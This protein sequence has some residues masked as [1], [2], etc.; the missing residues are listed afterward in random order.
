MSPEPNI[1]ETKLRLKTAEKVAT[2]HKAECDRLQSLTPDAFL[3]AHARE[4]RDHTEESA[5]ELAETFIDRQRDALALAFRTRMDE[6]IGQSPQDGAPAFETAL[7]WAR[8]ALALTPRDRTLLMLID[9][10]KGAAAIAAQSP[11]TV[12]LKNDADRQDRQT[13]ADRLPMDI[14]ALTAAFFKARDSGQYALMSFLAEHGLTITRRPPFG[15]GSKAHLMFRMHRVEALKYGGQAPDAFTECAALARPFRDVFGERNAR[16]C[17]LRSLLAQCRF[18]SG[19]FAGALEEIEALLPLQTEVRGARHPSVLVAQFLLA[20]CHN[21]TGDP[22][23][24]LA[25]VEALLTLQTDV[26]GPRHPSV[27][28]T[29]S[30]QAQ[31]RSDA[32]DP[33]GALEEIKAL[34]PLVTEVHGP[35]HPS[36]LATRSLQAHCRKDTGDPAGALAEIEDLLPLWTEVQGPRHPSV[37]ATRILRAEVLVDLDRPD[38]AGADLDDI[39]AGLIAARFLPDHRHLIRLNALK[40]R[41][42][43]PPT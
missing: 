31:I 4:M 24:A 20:Q 33:A 13:R 11:V 6:A 9:D 16:T 38:Q 19:D 23:G 10:L 1:N 37:L 3:A 17:Y 25:E 29:R 26:Q 40:D 34:L 35:R 42:A 28:A 2:E 8:A 41:L 21:L 36:V 22:A 14:D 27:L 18:E 30:L 5:M 7:T 39:G 32:G 15:Q 12:R 43:G